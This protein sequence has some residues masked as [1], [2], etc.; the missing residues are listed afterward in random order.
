MKY[1]FLIFMQKRFSQ[2]GAFCPMY[3]W[4]Q[5]ISTFDRSE[6]EKA[7]EFTQRL[8]DNHYIGKTEA[9]NGE[10]GYTI[11]GMGYEHISKG[12]LEVIL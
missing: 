9:S 4:E 10:I 8:I 5:F 2:A 11:T 1:T 6:R 12:I 3:L 7:W